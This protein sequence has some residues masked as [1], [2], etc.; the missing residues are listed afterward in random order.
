MKLGFLSPMACCCQSGR[1]LWFTAP[2]AERENH[3]G[4][5]YCRKYLT[6]NTPLGSENLLISPVAKLQ[7][8][9]RCIPKPLVSH[10]MVERRES[11]GHIKDQ[12]SQ[13]QGW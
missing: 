13:R 7:S 5:T 2:W 11:T 3:A 8:N 12:W 4:K 1:L 6:D 9:C 10:R